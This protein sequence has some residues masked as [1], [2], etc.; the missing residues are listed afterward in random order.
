MADQEQ[1]KN[2]GSGRDDS[3][4]PTKLAAFYRSVGGNYDPLF[5]E[6]PSNSLSFIYQC[7]GCAHSLQPTSDDFAPPSIPALTARGFVRWQTIQLLLGPEEHVPYLQEALRKYDIVDP[8][9][10][11][12]F[13]KVLPAEAFPEKPD[14]AMVRWHDTAFDRLKSEAQKEWPGTSR[15][16]SRDT[17]EDYFSFEPRSQ[18]PGDP[19]GGSREPPLRSTE[20]AYPPLK[21]D[22]NVRN[23]HRNV[24]ARSRS[25]P[26]DYHLPGDSPYVFQRPS[27]GTNGKQQSGGIPRSPGVETATT[28]ESG[29]MTEEGDD[30]DD[31]DDDSSI[32]QHGFTRGFSTPSG[33]FMELPSSSGGQSPQVFEVSPMQHRRRRYSDDQRYSPLYSARREG[34]YDIRTP[35]YLPRNPPPPPPPPPP[36]PAFLS[37]RTFKPP[38]RANYRGANVRWKNES[39]VYLFPAASSSMSG[40]S[41]G[42]GST[43]GPSSSPPRRLISSARFGSAD[44]SQSRSQSRSRED[45]NRRAAFIPIT[46]PLI[47][48]RLVS[49]V[50]GVDGRRYTTDGIVRQ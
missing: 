4:V 16:D 23:A 39:N 40:S 30:G 47:R 49:P 2:I 42:G 22:R 11:K 38:P 35:A 50:V 12:S 24:R 48:R 18:R 15:P 13:S 20:E 33:A 14:E 5:L 8:R 26:E 36:A 41:P 7:L 37:S 6:S 27:Y 3:L 31:D 25:F 17:S 1:S 45:R 34:R 43:D 19:G 21:R 46:K 28:S 10:G 32:I 44:R 9:S 29:S